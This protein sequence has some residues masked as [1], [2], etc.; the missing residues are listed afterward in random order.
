MLLHFSSSGDR[1]RGRGKDMRKMR[2]QEVVYV[3][4]PEN[5]EEARR[6]EAVRRTVRMLRDQGFKP[7]DTSFLKDSFGQKMYMRCWT[8]NL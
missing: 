7:D 4:I 3:P 8:R 6:D 1:I 5:N 2:T